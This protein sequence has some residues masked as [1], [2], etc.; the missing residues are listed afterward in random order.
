MSG[1]GELIKTITTD[2]RSVT[3]LVYSSDGGTLAS[4]SWLNKNIYLWDVQTGELLKTLKG[5]TAEVDFLAYD[6]AG[7]TLTSESED[8]TIRFWDPDNRKTSENDQ[9]TYVYGKIGSV[10][11]RWQHTYEQ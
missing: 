9:W 3:A 8:G 6:P 5:H 10:F 7:K 11:T 2:M 1:T 4:G